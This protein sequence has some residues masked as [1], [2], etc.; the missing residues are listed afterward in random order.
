MPGQSLIIIE[1]VIPKVIPSSIRSGSQSLPPSLLPRLSGWLLSSWAPSTPP[2]AQP[3][4]FT[5]EAALLSSAV[6]LLPNVFR[7]G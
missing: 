5:A 2:L 6:L 4:P 1:A 7:R 3:E